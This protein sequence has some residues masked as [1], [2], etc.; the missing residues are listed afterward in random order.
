MRQLNGA[1]AALAILLLGGS[2]AACSTAPRRTDAERAAD[3]DTASR[4]ESAFTADPTLFARHIDVSVDGGVVYLGGYV[5]SVEDLYLARHLAASVAGVR[6]VSSDME[7][8]RGGS[9]GR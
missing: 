4:V 2:L 8:M 5:W 7:L 9:K 6:S 1:L 3:A